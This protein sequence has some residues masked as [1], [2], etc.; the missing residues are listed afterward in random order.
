M[1]ESLYKS[2]AE[3]RDED[4]C[5]A[6]GCDVRIDWEDDVSVEGKCLRCGQPYQKLKKI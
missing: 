5:A 4:F 6:W 2:E 1:P 3:W